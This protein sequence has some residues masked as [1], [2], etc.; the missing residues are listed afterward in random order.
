MDAVEQGRPAGDCH[1]HCAEI[2]LL[3]VVSDIADHVGEIHRVTDE[4]VWACCYKAPQRR[5]NAE[6]SAQREKTEEAQTRRERY[7]DE[8]ELGPYPLA[9]HPAKVDDLGIRVG[10]RN[11][12]GDRRTQ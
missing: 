3:K 12:D 7:Q 9:G 11:N 4:P 2:P 10:I 6:E 5:T 8:S 1:K